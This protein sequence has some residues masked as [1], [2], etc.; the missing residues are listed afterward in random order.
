[1]ATSFA[2]CFPKE[3]VISK[4]KRGTVCAPPDG[5]KNGRNFCFGQLAIK[6][7]SQCHLR[8]WLAVLLASSCILLLQ[9]PLGSIKEAIFYCCE[10]MQQLGCTPQ[11]LKICL[12]SLNWQAETNS[13]A[14]DK[15]AG[16]MLSPSV[17]I[18]TVCVV[19]VYWGR[20][21]N[22]EIAKKTGF[23]SFCS[24]PQKESRWVIVPVKCKYLLFH[25][26]KFP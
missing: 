9:C 21:W 17:F 1:M 13:L 3:C 14:F 24:S 15:N 10:K 4:E 20:S 11:K 19:L 18:Q 23:I 16:K 25:K 12:N 22:A 8:D 5:E 2:Q 7:W 6:G 26:K